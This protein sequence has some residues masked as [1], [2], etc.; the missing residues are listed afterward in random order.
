MNEFTKAWMYR[1]VWFYLG[2]KDV[3]LR[4][5]RAKIGVAWVLLNNVFFICFMAFVWSS[6]FKINLAD[7]LIFFAIGHI[8]WGFFSSSINDASSLFLQ[9]ESIIKQ[10]R[11]PYGVYSLRVVFR[12][13]FILL[14]NLPIIF[15]LMILNQGANFHG[16]I[17]SIF[18][19]FLLTIFIF[20]VVNFL[21]VVCLR[22][23]DIQQLIPSLMTLIFF[24]SPIMW[25][26][27][28]LGENKK[29][30]AELNPIYHMF[31]IIRN[32]MIG[33]SVDDKSIL[34]SFL[35][36]VSAFLI[37]IYFVFKS[38]KKISILI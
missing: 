36:S 5:R 34:I 10:Y 14:L 17:L 6:L 15:F 21:G 26:K 7:Y 4:Y 23:R 9:F 22:Y 16:L 24:A 1:D 27:D 2:W 13:L 38:R 32:P 28:M 20:G 25:S 18:G 3:S 35:S 8:F 12:N 37:G 33:L 19:I 31:S 29:W 30:V 11:L